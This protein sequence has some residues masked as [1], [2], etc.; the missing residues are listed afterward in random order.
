MKEGDVIRINYNLGTIIDNKVTREFQGKTGTI[1]GIQ[2]SLRKNNKIFK[3]EAHNKSNGC[4]EYF[5]VYDMYT[6]LVD[7]SEYPELFI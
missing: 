1:V 5:Y 7:S 6:E 2:G 4:D 3:V